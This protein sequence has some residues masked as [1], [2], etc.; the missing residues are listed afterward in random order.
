MEK[1]KPKARSEDTGLDGV[2][3]RTPMEHVAP[4]SEPHLAS[5]RILGCRGLG[6]EAGE[7]RAALSC[8]SCSHSPS[9]HLVND[10]LQ[11]NLSVRTGFHQNVMRI[12]FSSFST[13][14]Q[15]K[16]ILY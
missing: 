8:F 5:V 9:P 12:C 16:T 2:A 13:S 15:A 4:K 14:A 6:L 7:L 3:T 11:T 10:L 1:E